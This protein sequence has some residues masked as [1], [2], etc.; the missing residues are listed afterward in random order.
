M[1]RDILIILVCLSFLIIASCSWTDLLYLTP[2][3]W[4]PEGIVAE[5][6][7]DAILSENT[8]EWLGMEVHNSNKSL[9][10]RYGIDPNEKGVV[11]IKVKPESTAK[12]LGFIEGDLIK[13]IN[14]LETNDV[15]QFYEA[16]QIMKGQDVNEINFTILRLGELQQILCV[17]KKEG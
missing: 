13:K 10:S 14:E 8:A 15:N 6:A 12:Q 4:V 9:S 2:V 11:I 1:K 3:G 7:L 17:I 5:I 16:T